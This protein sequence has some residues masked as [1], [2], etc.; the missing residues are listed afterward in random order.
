MSSSRPI[1][2]PWSCKV[3]GEEEPDTEPDTAAEDNIKNTWE[4]E[5]WPSSTWTVSGT[6]V[7]QA[8]GRL[9]HTYPKPLVEHEFVEPEH[10]GGRAPICPCNGC[11]GHGLGGTDAMRI[12]CRRWMNP[13]KP[14]ACRPQYQHQLV[15]AEEEVEAAEHP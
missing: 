4:S 6:G 5:N 9:Q 3:R 15:G 10:N 7:S 1:R 12:A 8:L 11:T 2:V 14:H 13:W